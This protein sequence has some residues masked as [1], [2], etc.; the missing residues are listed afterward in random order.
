MSHAPKKLKDI[1]SG[2]IFHVEFISPVNPHHVDHEWD[3]P[4]QDDVTKPG[5]YYI[6]DDS[7]YH[8]YFDGH[9][10]WKNEEKYEFL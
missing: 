3:L 4:Y 8:A 10:W 5:V 2:Q 1:E 7:P 9:R 6:C